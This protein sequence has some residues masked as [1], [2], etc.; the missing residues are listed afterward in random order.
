MDQ[1]LLFSF[2]VQFLIIVSKLSA[3]VSNH[4]IRITQQ[5]HVEPHM[6]ERL[7]VDEDLRNVFRKRIWRRPNLLRMSYKKA[8][9][10][11]GISANCGCIIN[12]YV[13]KTK[14][15]RQLHKSDGGDDYNCATIFFVVT[16]LNAFGIFILV[17]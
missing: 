14:A 15:I 11:F 2:F 5:F 9:T 6:G 16:S 10:N 1:C 12:L 8:L 7:P 3:N 13:T 17:Q 4:P